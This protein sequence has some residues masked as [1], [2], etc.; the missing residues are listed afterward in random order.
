MKKYD[1]DGIDFKIK[2]R[3]NILKWV[4]VFLILAF[5]IIATFLNKITIDLSN[6]TFS[7]LIAII[8]SLWAVYISM[9]FYHKNNEATAEF[10]NNFY[11]FIKDVTEKIGKLDAGVKEG[12]EG[13]KER[14]GYN[15][16]IGPDKDYKK[17]IEEL[18]SKNTDNNKKLEDSEKE[19]KDILSELYQKTKASN[20]MQKKID[21]LTSEISK[22]KNNS[23]I[24]NRRLRMTSS[25]KD[26]Y[27]IIEDLQEG[28]SQ[29][30]LDEMMKEPLEEFARD[31]YHYYEAMFEKDYIN[32]LVDKQ[33]LN[34]K[35]KWLNLEAYR[36]LIPIYRNIRSQESK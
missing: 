36:K 27:Q 19:L 24:L 15:N 10:Y 30:R 28:Y 4:F 6:F 8:I 23:N 25:N 12:M 22:Y 14:V 5:I 11:V 7:D 3:N 2:N 9:L 1:T 20:D 26:L 18:E 17:R 34:D 16:N 13:L 35:D 31:I 33:I 29:K 32:Y 21:E